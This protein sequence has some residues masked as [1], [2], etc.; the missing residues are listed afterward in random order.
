MS[1]Q[2]T[3]EQVAH[4]AHLA[5]LAITDDEAAKYAIQLSDVLAHASD[6]EALDLAGVMP[7]SHP[8]PLCNVMRA[9]VVQ[10]SLPVD[11]VL[12]MAPSVRDEMFL[13]PR[14]LGEAP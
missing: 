6:I 7:T 3:Q 9:D 1:S 4:V 5:R 10:P 12:A 8:L 2:I 11:V 14:I 13:V